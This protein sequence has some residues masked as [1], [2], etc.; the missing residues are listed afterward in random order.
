MSAGTTTVHGQYFDGHE[1]IG[2]PAT[3]VFTGKEAALI[4][5]KISQRY[6][7]AQL[8]VSPRIGRAERFV[9]LPDGGQFQCP[10]NP[11]LDRLPHDSQ[12]EGVVAWLEQRL[13]VAVAGVVLIAAVI[14]G[15]YFFG[16]PALA[17]RVAARVPIETEQA[18]GD[19]TLAWFDENH[20]FN[21]SRLKPG[22]RE[23]LR[24]GFDDLRS[25]LPQAQHYRLEF[26]DAPMVGANAFALP[27]GTI[28]VT[29][30]MVGA[31][32]SP[33]ELF[34]V[35]AHEM[36]HVEHRHAL[37]TLLQNSAVGVA[38]TAVTGDA[39]SLSVAVAGLP[40]MLAQAKYSRTFELEADDFAFDL[41]KQHDISPEYFAML[42]ERLNAKHGGPEGAFRYISSH[43][44]TQERIRRARAAAR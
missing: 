2:S 16:L 4:G 35:F 29:D 33:Q 43:P 31:A 8:L 38:A 25:G 26:R 42:M 12:A 13:S 37:R 36:G 1:P 41:L 32:E 7:A 28:V 34:A 22:V 39:A 27:G 20:W 9:A 23:T 17:E 3:L 19:R 24:Q 18:L 21:P 10:D 14:L 40:I 44:L 6:R 11:L 15:G 5:A 30:A